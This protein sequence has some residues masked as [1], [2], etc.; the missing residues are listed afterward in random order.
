MSRLNIRMIAGAKIFALASILAVVVALLATPVLAQ[1]PPGASEVAEDQV[2]DLVPIWIFDEDEELHKFVIE[3]NELRGYSKGMELIERDC[4]GVHMP[5][6]SLP[7]GDVIAYRALQVAFEQLWPEDVPNL[8]D[9]AVTY[10]NPDKDQQVALEYVTQAFS[11]GEGNVDPDPGV[12]PDNFGADSYQYVFTNLDSE[13]TFETHVLGEVFPNDFFDLWM[14]VKAG[15]ATDAEKAAYLEEFEEVRSTFLGAEG[16]DELFEVEAEDEP[17]PYWQV[18][19]TLGLFG[20]TI[21]G[22][23]YSYLTR[24]RRQTWR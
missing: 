20:F 15:T 18:V 21:V 24:R 4:L 13:E 6:G 14:K 10:K 23:G 3:E 2:E 8:T 5:R 11:R 17:V 19:F 1:A 7:L 16:L 9:F 12:T 22:T